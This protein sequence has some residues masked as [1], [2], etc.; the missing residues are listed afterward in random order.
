MERRRA[1]PAV[2]ESLS[3]SLRKTDQKMKV[4]VTG[5]SGF[6]ASWLIKRLLLSGYHVTRTVRDPGNDKM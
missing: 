5:A 6:L 2:A 1:A 4:C 3:S